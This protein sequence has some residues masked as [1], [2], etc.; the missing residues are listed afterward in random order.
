VPSGLS[1]GST[2]IITPQTQ[3][4]DRFVKL[5]T[6]NHRYCVAEFNSRQS[7]WVLFSPRLSGSGVHR[8]FYPVDIGDDSILGGTTSETWSR[9]LSVTDYRSHD[10]HLS[11]WHM[12]KKQAKFILPYLTYVLAHFLVSGNKITDLCGWMTRKLDTE[13]AQLQPI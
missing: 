8:A 1:Q 12:F 3:P 6:G 13:H 4:C 2:K 10:W 9:L 11:S 7:Q 5:V